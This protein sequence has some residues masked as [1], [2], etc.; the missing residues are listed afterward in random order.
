MPKIGTTPEK[1]KALEALLVAMVESKV[2][3]D[4]FKWLTAV[5]EVGFELWRI[6]DKIRKQFPAES[7]WIS[8]VLM[9]E[10]VEREVV[11]KSRKE[12]IEAARQTIEAIKEEVKNKGKSKTTSREAGE[13]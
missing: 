5:E 3:R 2:S 7:A 6:V 4:D 13:E 11:S 10:G 8:G 1:I 9:A 12:V